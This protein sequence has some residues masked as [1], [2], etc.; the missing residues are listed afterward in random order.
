[1]FKR[2]L[3]FLLVFAVMVMFSVKAFADMVSADALR[4]AGKYAEA[5]ADYA[6]VVEAKGTDATVAQFYIGHCYAMEKNYALAR[7]EYAKAVI[8]PD[9]DHSTLAQF[10]IGGIYELEG[11]TTEAQEAYKAVLLLKTSQVTWS[12]L[13]ALNKIDFAL[14]TQDDADT[15]LIKAYRTVVNKQAKKIGADGKE[16]YIYTDYLSALIANM[17]QQAQA[18]FIK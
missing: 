7:T 14:M 16:Y 3:S 9:P 12:L 6:T 10:G 13:P 2:I 11:K 17:S 1:M 8:M 5:R 15:L 4:L 18:L